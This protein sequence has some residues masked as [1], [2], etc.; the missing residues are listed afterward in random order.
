MR[1]NRKVTSAFGLAFL[2]VM[3]CGLGAVTLIFMLVKYQTNVSE[4]EQT[5]H[6]NLDRDLAQL[7][8]LHGVSERELE[9]LIAEHLALT[10]QLAERETEMAARLADHEGREKELLRL[11]A[12]ES[13]LEKTVA[14]LDK[15][16]SEEPAPTTPAQEP[17]Q[18]HLLGIRVEGPRILI[19]VDSSASMTETRIVDILK[20]QVSDDGAKRSAPKWRRALETVDWLVERAP[21]DSRFMIVHYDRKPGFVHGNRWIDPA[22]EERRN[23]ALG[24]LSDLVPDDA[25]N[26]HD[27]LQ[28]ITRHGLGPSSIYI[29]TDGL[30]TLGPVPGRSIRSA[31]NC[32][33]SGL[34]G[35]TISGPCRKA[36]FF[37]AIK[38]YHTTTGAT[39]N[40]V[41]LPLEGDPEAIHAYWTW[42]S[43]TGGTVTSPVSGWP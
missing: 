35:K 33:A 40:A 24:K 28:F 32:S 42:A 34:G 37:D 17:T 39:V 15:A 22:D 36:L 11:K 12:E 41:L 30:P 38:S 43:S 25:T 14:A 29:V 7:E 8:V 18:H 2:D 9:D 16:V 27:A 13:V 23:E 3:A 19:L 31:T 21:Q 20:I 1:K 5:D 4:A 6:Q 10:R 26:F